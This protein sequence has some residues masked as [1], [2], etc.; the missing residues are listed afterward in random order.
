MKPAASRRATSPSSPTPTPSPTSPRLES[1]EARTL[2]SAVPFGADSRDNSEFM[3]GDVFVTVVLLESDGSIDP[4]Q[5]D[6]TTAEIDSVKSEIEEGAQW[7]RDTLAAQFPNSPHALNFT[8]DF[9]HDDA[10]VATGYE[11]I[12]PSSEDEAL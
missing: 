1:L 11:P 10:P 2:L 4:N 3:I 7:W 5:E 6:W 9:T 8:F 12:T